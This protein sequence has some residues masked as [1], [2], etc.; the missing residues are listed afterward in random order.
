MTE[1]H[2]PWISCTCI[3]EKIQFCRCDL[4]LQIEEPK[5]KTDETK[6]QKAEE[7][8]KEVPIKARGLLMDEDDDDE[9]FHLKHFS[10]D[11]RCSIKDILF[12]NLLLFK[13]QIT[14]C[15]SG[16]LFMKSACPQ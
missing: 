15:Q 3:D 14:E 13:S 6:E 11:S 4:L 9:V 2:V 16:T 12:Y 1:G 7:E 10:F 8:K 5:A